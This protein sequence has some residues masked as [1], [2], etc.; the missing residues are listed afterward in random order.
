MTAYK[1]PFPKM[2][3]KGSNRVISGRSHLFHCLS[4]HL[5]S[6]CSRLGPFFVSSLSFSNACALDK[7][8]KY[9]KKTMAIG[10]TIA[11]LPSFWFPVK[12][13]AD[14][15]VEVYISDL[16]WGCDSIAGR[17]DLQGGFLL[18]HGLRECSPLYW[19]C[20]VTAGSMVG[21]HAARL[22]H[23]SYLSKHRARRRGGV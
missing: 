16:C 4:L 12:H 1:P 2:L 17:S 11:A 7:M 19:R 18:G 21:E 3:H 6:V 9:R 15:E 22:L 8:R 14:K 20:V 10:K 5:G 23:P 13:L